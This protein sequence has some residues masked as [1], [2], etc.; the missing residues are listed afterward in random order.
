MGGLS[1][2]TAPQLGAHAIK[3]ALE[4]SQGV[5]TSDVDEVFMGN[6]LSANV[7]QNPARQMALGA[8]LPNTVVATTINKV[9]AASTKAVILG[10]QTI[11]T[12]SADVVIAGGAESMSNAPH[13]ITGHRTGSKYGEGKLLDAIQRDGLTDAYDGMIMGLAAEHCAEKYNISREDQDSF[14]IE[15][16]QRAQA[17]AKRGE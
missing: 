8:G 17:A 1:S 4:R 5:S 9:C 2:L 14:A 7:G 3:A 10:A 13:Y 11:M 12:G 6:V 15:S 16:Y